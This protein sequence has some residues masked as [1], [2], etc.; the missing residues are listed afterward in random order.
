MSDD[1]R[2]PAANQGTGLEVLLAALRPFPGAE[3]VFR[4]LPTNEQIGL[5]DWVD[6]V[7]GAKNRARRVRMVVA[8]LTRV[9][10]DGSTEA[11]SSGL[12][13]EPSLEAG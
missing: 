1:A 9:G 11:R 10:L 5:M 12:A 4:A 3:E 6:R 2:S 7:S 8:V 13:G